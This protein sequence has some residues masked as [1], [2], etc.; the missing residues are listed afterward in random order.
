M[1]TFIAIPLT[2]ECQSM[3]DR[4]QGSLRGFHAD[5]RWVA[6]PS[7]HL[8]LKFLGEVDPAVIP[9]LA[10][11]LEQASRSENA[12]EL[13]LQGL[14]CFPNLR[15]P[16]V[17]WCG[18]EGE[19]EKLARLHQTVEA[20]CASQGFTLEERSFH[21]HL[22]LGRVNGKRNLQPLLDCIKIGPDLQCGFKA[23]HYNVYKSTLRPQ[24]A[25]YMVL[26]TIALGGQAG[27]R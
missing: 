25:E 19:T 23:D 2:K 7:I 8:T 17:I 22:T 11:S 1:R 20:A 21:P 15:N 18:I 9:A 10:E 16:R 26:K 6:I 4:L 13:R 14:G 27:V 5:V 12:F 24:G 3:L